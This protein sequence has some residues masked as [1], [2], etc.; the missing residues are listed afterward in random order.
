MTNFVYQ[1]ENN[2]GEYYIGI[3]KGTPDDG[4]I[5]S[6]KVFS[7]RYEENSNDWERTIIAN[8]LTR[9]QAEWLER[10]MVGYDTVSDSLCLNL[11]KGGHPS[12][13][14]DPKVHA[15]AMANRDSSEIARKGHI[16]RTDYSKCGASQPGLNNPRATPADVSL[17]HI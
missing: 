15:K 4:Y 10:A 1:W 11:V 17:I 2:N 7:Q 16:K 9:G 13:L 14:G 5:G 3:H 6:G 8:D 12:S